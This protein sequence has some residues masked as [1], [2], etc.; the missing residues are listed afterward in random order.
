MGF[1]SI[2]KSENHI[3][4][5]YLLGCFSFFLPLFPSILPATIIL[6]FIHQL[7]F[8]NKN[9]KKSNLKLFFLLSSLY[10]LYLLG[11]LYTQNY[12]YAF[13]DLETKLALLIFP[14]LFLI[15]PRINEHSRDSI[16]KLFI[17]GC[18]ASIALNTIMSFYFLI[19]EKNEIS[20][21]IHNDNFGIYFFLKDRVSHFLH[22][23]YLSMYL[24][25]AF[26]IVFYFYEIKKTISKFYALI[27]LLLLSTFIL[28]LASKAGILLLFIFSIYLFAYYI[29]IKKIFLIP[30]IGISILIA[31]FTMLHN[32]VP[33]FGQRI[34]SSIKAISANNDSNNNPES[35][36]ARLRIWSACISII[37]EHAVV[38]V[39]TGDVKDVLLNKYAELGM[40]NELDKKYNAHN[41]FLQTFIAL[42]IA[43]F[44]S[45]CLL[46]LA[47]IK[48]ALRNKD[49]V[50]IFF[51]VIFSINILFE[52]MLEVQAGVL[53]FA[54]FLSLLMFTK[55]TLRN[56]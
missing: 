8:F 11:L 30:V 3:R 28:L 50:L 56:D 7:I 21:G 29:F 16:L 35:S 1:T 32:F 22:P 49:Y 38:G 20:N 33:E 27:L 13:K 24:L 10:I 19:I 9:I 25:F 40:N 34:D 53:F 45:L 55:P 36:F 46:L 44:L 31:A 47:P 14:L 54:F 23:S 48:S 17:W 6:L 12:S 43:G 2:I 39:G 51:L 41:Q 4:F 15:S 26:C 42:G 52:S 37:K 5:E 18:I